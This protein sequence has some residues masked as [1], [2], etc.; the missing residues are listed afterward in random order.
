MKTKKILETLVLAACCTGSA[1]AAILPLQNALITGTYNGQAAGMLGNDLNF[2]PNS[3]TTH[4]DPT[5]TGAEFLTSDDLFA[6]DFDA[7]G[8]VTVYANL[9]IPVGAYQ[10]R[11]DFGSSVPAAFSSFTLTDMGGNGG[12]PVL[13]LINAHT[14]QFDLGNVS[15]NGAF[16][17]FSAQIGTVP[18]PGSITLLLGGL[19]GLALVRRPRA[20]RS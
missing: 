18:E 13:S 4:L 15:W 9:D 1:H 7:S 11:F 19:A 10:M 8:N 20:T 16:S 17:S 14:I 12:A 6:F 3:N 5:N 2:G